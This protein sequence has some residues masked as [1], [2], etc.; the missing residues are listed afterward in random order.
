MQK[1]LAVLLIVTLSACSSAVKFSTRGKNTPQPPKN[2]Q[3]VMKNIP[4][5][6]NDVLEVFEGVASYYADKFHGRTTANG[7]TYNMYDLTAAHNNFPFNTIIRVTNL[8]NGRNC[9]IRINDRMPLHP[10][11][12]I[13]LSLGTARE[14]DMVNAGLANV[15]LEILKWG[16]R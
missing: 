10:N 2:E 9:I 8:T 15:R 6:G 12:I 14:L 1:V 11:R 4:V 7:E 13:D 5:P 3:V 16:D